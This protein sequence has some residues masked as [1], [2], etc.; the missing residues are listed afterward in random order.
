MLNP[1]DIVIFG[2]GGDLSL[3]KLLPA[4]YRAYQEGNLPA[5]SRIM[6]TVRELANREEFIEKVN[7]GLQDHLSKG[8]YNKKDW[9]AFAEF[10]EPIEINVT[11]IDD[12]WTVLKERLESV[13]ADRSRVFY[14]SLRTLS[15]LPIQ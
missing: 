9:T 6:P 11:E 12:N 1:F 10:I 15:Y 3:R 4:W 14:L 2:G 7:Q 8:E 5:G 13:E